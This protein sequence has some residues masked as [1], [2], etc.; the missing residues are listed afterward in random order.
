[1]IRSPAAKRHGECIGTQEVGGDAM[2]VELVEPV[3][4][5]MMLHHGDGQLVLLARRHLRN[6]EMHV[7]DVVGDQLLDHIGQRLLDLPHL[8]RGNVG[9]REEDELARD[10]HDRLAIRQR[11]A[12][13]ALQ[14]AQGDAAA[15]LQA[16]GG[17]EQMPIDE[18]VRID[19]RR[20]QLDDQMLLH[21]CSLLSSLSSSDRGLRARL[22]TVVAP[23]WLSRHTIVRRRCQR[24]S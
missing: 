22:S 20:A 7:L 6:R 8:A 17:A 5:K 11:G 4:Q 3:D 9:R 14:V 18:G 16:A 1:M 19:P 10:Q 24:L 12:D 15:P 2:L 21:G 13:F 23:E